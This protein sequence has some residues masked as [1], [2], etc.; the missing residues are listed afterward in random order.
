MQ[1]LSDPRLDRLTALTR[2]VEDTTVVFPIGKDVPV[3]GDMP[4]LTRAVDTLADIA[5]L[6][7]KMG[8]DASL[9]INGHADATGTET[10]NYEISLSW[11][12]TIAA[13]L[14]AWGGRIPVT[15]YGMGAD[16]ANR[17]KGEDDQASQR[18]ELRVHLAR[19]GTALLDE[20]RQ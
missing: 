13:M 1:G 12:K 4:V 7:A 9:V 17:E 6:A 5:D 18:I 11:A 16:Y 8:M 20:I 3:A 10:R 2:A 14:Y 15:I 19:A